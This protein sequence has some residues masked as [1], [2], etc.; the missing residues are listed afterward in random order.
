R[1]LL[2]P[3][4]DSSALRV[5][6]HPQTGP[7]VDNLVPVKVESWSQLRQLLALGTSARSE[8]DTPEN[9][10]SSRG[11]AI[12]TMEVN[13]RTG[14]SRV[15]MVDLAGSEREVVTNSRSS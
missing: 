5:R 7:Y 14:L 11:H 4:A 8:A 1:D 15:Q 12:L 10:K 13:T 6:E 2:H 3:G 9:I